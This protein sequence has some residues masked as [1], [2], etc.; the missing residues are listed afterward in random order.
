VAGG[1]YGGAGSQE[2]KVLALH[3][4]T[5][6][7]TSMRGELVH[8]ERLGVELICPDAPNVC[9]DAVVERLYAVWNAPRKD[10]PYCA[11]W[12]ASDDGRTYVGWE[13]TRELVAPLLDRGPLG[14]VGFSQGAILATALA[15]L[16]E[17]GELPPIEYVVL[18]AGRSPRAD[19]FA[20][21]LVEPLRTP[22]LHVWGEKDFL[23]GTTSREL[24]D[25]FA[26]EHR[27]VV[28]WPGSH[29]IPTRGPAADAIEEF[30]M[31]A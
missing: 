29:M 21:Y 9:P 16:S 22:S 8:L 12:D 19:V 4:Q 24:V 27:K 23:V 6:N 11:W 2:V 15:A 26:V 10:P 3:G 28:T 25:R 31:R 30:V 7:G 1:E 13:K 20:P 18:I 5:L 14:I 17:H